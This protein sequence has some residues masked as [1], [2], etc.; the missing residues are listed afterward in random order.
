MIQSM[1]LLTTELAY[2]LSMLISVSVLLHLTILVIVSPPPVKPSCNWFGAREIVNLTFLP[3][4]LVPAWASWYLAEQWSSGA[5][6]GM[7]IGPL[8]FLWRWTWHVSYGTH[9]RWVFAYTVAYFFTKL[10]AWIFTGF[11][12]LNSYEKWLPSTWLIFWVSP[13]SSRKIDNSLHL[14]QRC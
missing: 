12:L 5:F 3:T 9:A 4:C 1:S 2:A 14:A 10:R 7:A 6:N 13:D 11:I 8:S